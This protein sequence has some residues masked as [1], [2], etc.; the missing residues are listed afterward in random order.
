LAAQVGIGYSDD[1]EKAKAQV[2]AAAF[3]VGDRLGEIEELLR[4]LSIRRLDQASEERLQDVS[5]EWYSCGCFA[6]GS[7]QAYHDCLT[8]DSTPR[9]VLDTEGEGRET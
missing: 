9:L 7:V 2:E 5:K 3:P 1:V 6:V 4:R 8:G